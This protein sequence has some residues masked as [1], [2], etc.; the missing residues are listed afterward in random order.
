MVSSK[1][2]TL[3]RRMI[4][5]FAVILGLTSSMAFSA[6]QAA[7]AAGNPPP[8]SNAA[9]AGGTDNLH[10]TDHS[11]TRGAVRAKA[12]GVTAPD[13]VTPLASTISQQSP[14][15]FVHGYSGASGGSSSSGGGKITCEG[16]G[17]D[18]SNVL[19]YLDWHNHHPGLGGDTITQTGGMYTV[20]Y[21][22]QDVR[23]DFNLW[24]YNHNWA[25]ACNGAGGISN[26]DARVGTNNEPLEHVACELAWYIYDNWS[27]N[28]TNAKVVAFSMGGLI[29]RY[30]I[31]KSG[32][33]SHFPPMLIVSDVVTMSSPLG[34]LDSFDTQAVGL[35]CGFCLQVQQMLR[36]PIAQPPAYSNFM[37]DIV[38]NPHPNGATGTD[39]TMFGSLSPDDPLDWDYRA[40]HLS[41]TTSADNHRI[42]FRALPNTLCPDQPGWPTGY[43][44]G[45]DYLSDK[46]EA[47]DATYFYCDGCSQDKHTLFT[48]ANGSAPHSLHN[49]L[50]AFV[51]YNW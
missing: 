23:C 26:S 24:T 5:V 43:G 13:G 49:M 34:G 35:S 27:V 11:L 51:Y 21:Y 2:K 50:L 32:V 39:W 19:D 9:P 8:N 47:Y 22:R 36:D 14:I 6:Q 18:F 10:G 37:L 7:H 3:R 15:I 46:C 4:V 31:Q 16:S 20:G 42:G 1:H 45:N 12:R 44:H 29:I 38:S 40:T 25:P 33:D 48:K 30:A 28:Y 17:G 41:N